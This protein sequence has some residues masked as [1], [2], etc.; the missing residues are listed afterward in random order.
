MEKAGRILVYD[1]KQWKR[2]LMMGRWNLG[3]VA[4]TLIA[5]AVALAACETELVETVERREPFSS[6]RESEDGIVVQWSGYTAG[7]E[8]GEEAAVEAAFT[9]NSDQIWS[10]RFCLQLLDRRQGD[11]EI[12]GLDERGFGLDPGV[13]QSSE[14]AFRVPA[15]LEP[16]AYGLALVVQRPGGPM[17]DV[18]AIQI[19]ET[20]A[21][22]A[23]VTAQ[24]NKASLAACLPGAAMGIDVYWVLGESI[25]PA[26]R[27]VVESEQTTQTVLQFDELGIQ[28]ATIAVA[29]ETE[30][31]L[32]P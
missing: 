1:A 30:G 5:V 18:I 20:G 23:P 4:V 14:V 29:G 27:Y 8:P 22:F 17:V 32:Q 24:E 11:M 21:A 31:V 7:Y 15:D 10:V 12:I 25:T 19:G 13:G 16:G 9:N 28:K 2:G 26:Q 3:T 6:Q